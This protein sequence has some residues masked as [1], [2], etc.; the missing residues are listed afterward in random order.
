MF[1]SAPPS[2]RNVRPYPLAEVKDA[3]PET[4]KLRPSMTPFLVSRTLE[5]AVFPMEGDAAV[6]M[7]TP[8]LLK[9]PPVTVAPSTIETL[10]AID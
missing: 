8:S 5:I 2:V 4:A 1:R 3:A 6:G 7:N 9:E 10:S